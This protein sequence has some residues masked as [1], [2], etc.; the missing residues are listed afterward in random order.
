MQRH[1]K[2]LIFLS[3]FLITACDAY[4]I[5]PIK[6]YE[7]KSRVE[8]GAEALEIYKNAVPDVDL[9]IF[10]AIKDTNFYQKDIWN[11]SGK[12]DSLGYFNFG[13]I[14]PWQYAV[15]YGYIIT[16]KKGY[17]KDT[18]R[19]MYDIG[20]SIGKYKVNIEMNRNESE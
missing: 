17:I 8:S 11:L 16:S 5:I 4:I 15:Q 2:Y 9:D 18:I 6:T 14:V 20:D 10:Y 7:L 13:S 1:L 12:T 3:A 19:I